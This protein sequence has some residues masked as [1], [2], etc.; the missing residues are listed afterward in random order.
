MCLCMRVLDGGMP[1]ICFS[2]LLLI[3]YLYQGIS[4]TTDRKPNPNGY[5]QKRSLL[6][7]LIKNFRDRIG[8]KYGLFELKQDPVFLP[9]L[10]NSRQGIGFTFGLHVV[11][12]WQQKLQL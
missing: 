7:L 2:L 10:L 5:K 11:A 12:H 8:F 3:V 9:L 1:S 6:V 4:D